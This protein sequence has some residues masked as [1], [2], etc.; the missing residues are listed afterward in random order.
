[1]NS[2]CQVAV[3]CGLVIIGS[4]TGAGQ[5]AEPPTGLLCELMAQPQ[6]ARITDA[7]PEFGWIVNSQANGDHQTA[8]QIQVASAREKLQHGEGDLWDSGKVESRHSINVEYAGRPLQSHHAYCW[9]VRTWD[10][11]GGMSRF[12]EVQE[13]RTGK[14]EE[15]SPDRRPGSRMERPA[16]A[17]QFHIN[18]YPLVQTEVA[19]VRLV[20]R[21][22][23]HWFVDFGRAAFGYLWLEVDGNHPGQEI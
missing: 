3:V 4:L 22:E 23:G 1:M 18:R 11:A 14:L 10:R 21:G 13:F 16:E 19:P 7:R 8:Y 6:L 9:R 2:V 15:N 12:S 17:E 20:C 5:A